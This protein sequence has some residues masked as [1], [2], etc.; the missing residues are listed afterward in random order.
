M[1]AR[2][3]TAVFAMAGLFAA[4]G[5]LLIVV[6]ADDVSPDYRGP[7]ALVG[8]LLVG[9][10]LGW[11]GARASWNGRRGELGARIQ[12][13]ERAL[14]LASVVACVGILMTGGQGAIVK[15]GF[16]VEGTGLLAACWIFLRA[17]PEGDNRTV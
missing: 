13:S 2:R 9:L 5:S 7:T 12:K 16:I 15:F 17:V 14:S 1:R 3:V 6:L 4:V 8:V 11:F 10:L